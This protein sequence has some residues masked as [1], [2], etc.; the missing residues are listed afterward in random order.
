MI[1][2]GQAILA[3]EAMKMKNL[4]AFTVG[5]TTK[6]VTPRWASRCLVGK[7]RGAG[8]ALLANARY[9]IAADCRCYA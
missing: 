5:R 1:E 7:S 3:V 6:A 8:A 9:F 4:H 2:P